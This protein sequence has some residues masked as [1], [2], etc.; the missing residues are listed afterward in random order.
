MIAL[1]TLEDVRRELARRGVSAAVSPPTEELPFGTPNVGA[2][3]AAFYSLADELFY[4]GAGG[5]GKTFLELLLAL[6]PHCNSIIFRR[7]FAQFR[8]PE[9]IIEQSRRLIGD[10]GRLNENLFVWRDLPGGRSIEFGAMKDADD[11]QKYKGRA[12]DLKAFD[13][14]PEFTELQYRS[15]LAWLRSTSPGQRTRVVATG[16]PPTNAE[17]QWVITYW[18][19]WLDPHHPHPAKP[20]ELR[21]YASID[22]EDVARPN[23]EPFMHEGHLIQPR[24]RTFI[25]ARVEDNPYLMRTGYD[26]VL[27]S[28]PEPLRSQMRFGNFQATQTDDQ[29][30]VIPTA[31]VRAAQARWTDQ[32]PTVQTPD[33]QTINMPLSAI[34]NDPSRGGGDKNCIAKRYGAW[35]APIERYP[36]SAVPDGPAGAA[37]LFAAAGGSKSVPVQIDVIGVGASVYDHARGLGLSAVALNGSEAS[38]ATDKSGK[39][40]FVNKRAEWFWQMREALDPANG[41]DLA[42]PL[43]TELLADLCSARWKPTPRGVQVEPKADIKQRI[44]RSPDVGESVIYAFVEGANAWLQYAAQVVEA[45]NKQAVA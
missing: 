17:G 4:G 7:E 36:G 5:G 12:H 20:G 10:R 14:V 29:W 9:G 11:W 44:G 6:G 31:W 8:G 32:I 25:P 35:I 1:P 45:A 26:Q 24:S 3:T 21:W 27:N 30:Q 23:A 13:E 37:L 2:Q 33:G 34:G 16:N 28:L 15:S 39:L 41:Q 42:L 43:D 18:A 22:G 38:H 40:T 19:P